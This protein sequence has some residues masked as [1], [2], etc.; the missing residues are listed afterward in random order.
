MFNEQLKKIVDRVGGGIAA[1][2]M[3][4]DG[5]AVETYVNEK[6]GFDINIIGMEF[7]FILGQVKKAAKILHSP[8]AIEIGEVEE[9]V[10][11]A[12]QLTLV[13]RMLS[14]EYFLAVAL[15]PQGNFGKC[16]F[17][18]RMTAPQIISELVR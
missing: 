18:L 7:S 6:D 13:I 8:P 16:R 10:I 9:L 1:V 4:L 14:D 2:I 11:K 5:I 15:S 3:G 12:E 17:L